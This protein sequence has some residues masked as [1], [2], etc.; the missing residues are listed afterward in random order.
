[1]DGKVEWEETWWESSDWSGMREMGAQKAGCNASGDAWREA[2]T[3]RVYYEA[4]T[5]EP[6]VERNAQKWASEGI[7]NQEWEE[8]WGEHYGGAGEV[9]KWAYK[10]GKKDGDVCPLRLVLHSRTR[11]SC[12][13]AFLPFASLLFF[14]GRTTCPQGIADVEQRFRLDGLFTRRL[15]LVSQCVCLQTPFEA[16]VLWI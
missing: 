1:M 15:D 13:F 12:L 16:D 11:V 2:W 4:A 6:F 5:G 7:G 9:N 8:K 10:W 14:A 3:E